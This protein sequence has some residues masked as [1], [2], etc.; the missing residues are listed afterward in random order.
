ML[1]GVSSMQG[2]KSRL[3]GQVAEQTAGDAIDTLYDD[4]SRYVAAIALRLLGRDSEVEDLVQ[5]VFL[6][7]V[8]GIGK[9]RDPAATKAWLATL[10]VRTA[11]RRIRYNRVRRFVS[12]SETTDYS[13]IVDKNA[14]AA[15]RY[16]LTRCYETLDTL[17]ANQ[18]LAWVLR[19]IEGQSLETVAARC[20]C[21]LAS[22][23]R[24]VKRA[25]LRLQEVLGYE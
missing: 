14:S 16:L 1:M 3:A 25:Q 10:T 8:R 18:R 6:D 12:S 19:H 7:A 5:D 24:H 21:S 9:L 22:A 11:R 4:Y 2:G 13:G 17:P 23:K 20:E 15:E